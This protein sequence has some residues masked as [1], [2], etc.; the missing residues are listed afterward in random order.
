MKNSNKKLVA[1]LIILLLALTIWVFRDKIETLS[2]NN[3]NKP[4]YVMISSQRI[5]NDAS[6]KYLDKDGKE[7][8]IVN[9]NWLYTFNGGIE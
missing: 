4:E 8:K 7:T 2:L 5:G 9:I 3:F 6:I 1:I